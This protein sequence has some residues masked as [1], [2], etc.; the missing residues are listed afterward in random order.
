MHQGML[1][2]SGNARKKT[3]FFAGGAPLGRTCEYSARI[4]CTEFAN[5]LQTYKEC[6]KNVFENTCEKDG[7]LS[8]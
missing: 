8:L 3:F 7:R 1:G 2:N 5:I 6:I 4:L